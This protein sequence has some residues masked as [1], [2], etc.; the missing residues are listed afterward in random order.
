MDLDLWDYL[1]R[2]ILASQFESTGRDVVVTALLAGYIDNTMFV[3]FDIKFI[4]R[5]QKQRGNAETKTYAATSEKAIPI[6]CFPLVSEKTIIITGNPVWIH[7][8]A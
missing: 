7:L 6:S 4:R 8:Q 3:S 5:D 2:V 1:E